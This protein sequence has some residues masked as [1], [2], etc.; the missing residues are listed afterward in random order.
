MHHHAARA[1]HKLGFIAARFYIRNPHQ[2]AE[3]GKVVSQATAHVSVARSSPSWWA[4]R[5]P[6]SSSVLCNSCEGAPS[7]RRRLELT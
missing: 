5:W 4:R 3:H 1:F 2:I 6:C 7:N